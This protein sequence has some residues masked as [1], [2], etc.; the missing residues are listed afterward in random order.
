MFAGSG[1]RWRGG[2]WLLEAAAARELVQH[3]RRVRDAHLLE[4][5]PA[6]LERL[7][8]GLDRL[9]VADDVMGRDVGER[10]RDVVWEV[11]AL[12]QRLGAVTG[13]GPAA[14][15]QE[16]ERGAVAT[17]RRLGERGADLERPARERLDGDLVAREQRGLQ[18]TDRATPRLAALAGVPALTPAGGGEAQPVGGLGVAGHQ[19]REAGRV[20]GVPAAHKRALVRL[21]VR[22][23][24]ASA[25]LG[26][27]WNP[28]HPATL[29]LRDMDA[30]F[31]GLTFVTDPGRVFT[32]RAATEHL[33]DAALERIGAGSARVADI[34]TG[35]GVIAVTLALRAPQVEVW[36]SDTCARALEIASL[37]AERLGAQVHLVHGDLLEGL[38]RDLDLIVANLPYL[39]PDTPGYEDEPTAAVFSK[40]DGLDHYRRLIAG[41]ADHLVADGGIVL[42]FRGDVLEAERSE[43][44]WLRSRLEALVRTAA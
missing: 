31:H 16:R 44:P 43:L 38:P 22:L 3:E 21:A 32:P 14:E 25:L 42:Q 33:V 5:L 27:D 15:R 41:A 2:Q 35:S 37:N 24:V 18:R 30:R 4:V 13:L 12:A 36:A 20:R 8:H 19:Q 39:A 40:G 28:I 6:R 11:V 23:R 17:D 29:Y 1:Q 26:C 10:V 9:D 34:G 7:D